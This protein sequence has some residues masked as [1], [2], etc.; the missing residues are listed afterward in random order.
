MSDWRF[1]RYVSVG[2][3]RAKALK[4]LK[5]LRKKNPNIEP[6]VVEGR[7]LA[8]TWWGKAWNNNLERYADYANRIGRGRSY[9]RHRAVLDLQIEPG[10]VTALVQGSR[11]KPYSV[12]IKIRKLSKKTWREI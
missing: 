2:E 1:A 10:K 9:I 12:S 7:T 5:Q 8:K 6:V 11:A 3:K 4:K